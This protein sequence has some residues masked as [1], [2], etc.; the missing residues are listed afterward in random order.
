MLR[1]K[2]VV[3]VLLLLIP[4]SVEAEVRAN[5][6]YGTEFKPSPACGLAGTTASA[7]IATATMPCKPNG[8]CKGT[9]NLPA[10]IDPECNDVDWVMED[11]RVRV[12][13]AGMVGNPAGLIA[14]DGVAVLAD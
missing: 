11:V 4:A 1:S 9:L 7:V 2:F 6:I 12:Y 10:T 13:E 8:K 14:V 3:A 5:S